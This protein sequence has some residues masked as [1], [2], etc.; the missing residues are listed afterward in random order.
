MT[1][2][3]PPVAVP[4]VW[5]PP[6]PPVHPLPKQ[7]WLYPSMARG[8][9]CIRGQWRRGGTVHSAH[10]GRT[11]GVSSHEAHAR[12]A[13]QPR[14]RQRPAPTQGAAAAPRGVLPG[15]AHGT[16]KRHLAFKKHNAIKKNPRIQSRAAQGHSRHNHNGRGKADSST[17]IVLDH[18]P[19]SLLLP[20]VA[21]TYCAKTTRQGQ[22][23]A[24]KGHHTIKHSDNKKK[25][26]NG[27]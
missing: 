20:S 1:S 15:V 5:P 23:S 12:N 6:P 18:H 22:T 19:R 14:R 2:S 25:T 24:A 27:Q 9:A 13:W 10:R 8:C 7:L 11:G 21:K 4:A 17:P 16:K 3:S 26:L